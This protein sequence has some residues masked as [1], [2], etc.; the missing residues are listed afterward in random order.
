MQFDQKWSLDSDNIAL[1]NVDMFTRKFQSMAE[2]TG[3]F[4]HVTYIKFKSTEIITMIIFLAIVLYTI[5]KR[6]L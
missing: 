5:K 6:K 2:Y 1:N 4:Q 3:I